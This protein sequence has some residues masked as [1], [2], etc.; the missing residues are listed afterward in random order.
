[1]VIYKWTLHFGVVNFYFHGLGLMLL[2][3][4]CEFF[5]GVNASRIRSLHVGCEFF[6]WCEWLF[7]E[8]STFLWS[9]S[10]AFTLGAWIF[11]LA[12][13]ALEWEV[14]IL[15]CGLDL[16]LTHRGCEFFFFICSKSAFSRISLTLPHQGCALLYWSEWLWNEKPICIFCGFWVWR[17][18]L[19]MWIFSHLW[20]AL[21]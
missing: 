20:V 2:H 6:H 15:I 16:T 8:K 17:F 10:D 7:I 5:I 19:E 21:G 18:I 11:S 3:W 4:G 14:R 13:T 1:M 12:W 9:G